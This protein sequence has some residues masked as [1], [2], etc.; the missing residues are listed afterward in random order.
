MN[1]QDR[2]TY[3][4]VL[5]RMLAAGWIVEYRFMESAGIR[6]EWSKASRKSVQLLRRIVR[7]FQLNANQRTAVRFDQLCENSLGGHP[8]P[9]AVDPELA[10]F[11]R[12]SLN[13][14]QLSREDGDFVWFIRAMEE[15]GPESELVRVPFQQSPV[16]RDPVRASTRQRGDSK[17]RMGNFPN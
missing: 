2:G 1:T 3:V 15:F 11:W 12:E 14:L 9:G 5:E 17:R 10:R 13:Q 16:K 6:I 8:A 4:H 7:G